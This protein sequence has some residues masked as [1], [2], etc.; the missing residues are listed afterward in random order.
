M[1]VSK[2]IWYLEKRRPKTDVGIPSLKWCVN[3]G[4]SEIWSFWR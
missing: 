1:T 3:Q 2:I 4:G